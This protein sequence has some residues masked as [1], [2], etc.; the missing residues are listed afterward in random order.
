MDCTTVYRVVGKAG[1]RGPQGGLDT[2][3]GV[4]ETYEIFPVPTAVLNVLLRSHCKTNESRGS[5]FITKKN[6]PF[7]REKS[8][9]TSKYISFFSLTV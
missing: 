2:W 7:R 8:V 4:F 6:R 5:D 9:G 3:E 1:T